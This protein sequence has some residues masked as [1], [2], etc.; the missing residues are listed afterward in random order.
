MKDYSGVKTRDLP[1]AGREDLV[2][3]SMTPPPPGKGDTQTMNVGYHPTTVSHGTVSE[4][5]LQILS[6]LK[7][8]RDRMQ[9]LDDKLL[10]KEGERDGIVKDIS[11]LSLRLKALAKSITKK[12][13]LL[14]QF[15]RTIKETES[16]FQKITES[17]KT[18]L[19]VV[20]RDHSA[21]NKALAGH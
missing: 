15:D 14:E 17:T 13:S 18:L 19:G 6:I 16:A 1:D 20:K 9:D 10:E 3:A 7:G 21:L 11:T 8:L 4:D 5:E 2:Y 12:R